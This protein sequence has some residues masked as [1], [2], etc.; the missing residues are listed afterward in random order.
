M[1]IALS[2]SGAHVP[3]GQPAVKILPPKL[4]KTLV[5]ETILRSWSTSWSKGTAEAPA[6]M[7]IVT[8]T[9]P[10][11]RSALPIAVQRP[12]AT[13]SPT[14]HLTSLED[15][16]DVRLREIYAATPPRPARA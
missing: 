13:G 16:F 2:N 11:A 15:L 12:T 7:Q 8:A 14:H 5:P 4:L 6:G 10:N 3:G 1:S 9:N